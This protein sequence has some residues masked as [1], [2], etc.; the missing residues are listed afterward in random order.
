MKKHSKIKYP[1]AERE[2]RLKD[3]EDKCSEDFDKVIKR[4]KEISDILEATDFTQV[5]E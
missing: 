5:G 4:I 3:K 2:R 1:N